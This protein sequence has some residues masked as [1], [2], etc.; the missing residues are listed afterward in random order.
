MTLELWDA[1]MS[2]VN[3]AKKECHDRDKNEHSEFPFGNCHPR[4]FLGEGLQ[5]T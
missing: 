1:L 4:G 3:D 2:A 5:L